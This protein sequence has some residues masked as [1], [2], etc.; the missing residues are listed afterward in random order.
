MCHPV[1][2]HI[3]VDNPEDIPWGHQKSTHT[4]TPTIIING[5]FL[6]LFIFVF[7]SFAWKQIAWSVL[8]APVTLILS[9]RHTRK[10][11]VV[12]ANV[13]VKA[14]YISKLDFSISNL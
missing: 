2:T 3:R 9:F 4:T 8:S 10:V 5:N 6:F 12:N 11:I 1:E 13:V 14:I 7:F